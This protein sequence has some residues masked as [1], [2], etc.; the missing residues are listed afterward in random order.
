MIE[1]KDNGRGLRFAVSGEPDGDTTHVQLIGTT[2]AID[3]PMN[4]LDFGRAWWDWT[5]RE[6]IQN[7]FPTL[8]LSQREFFQ[9]GMTAEE[10]DKMCDEI[11]EGWP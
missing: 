11:E 6:L 7:A 3:V 10:W 1:F 8:T 5:R 2:K 4:F 9:T